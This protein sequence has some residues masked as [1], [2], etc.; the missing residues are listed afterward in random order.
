MRE[1]ISAARWPNG[2]TSD[3]T[4]HARLTLSY[5]DWQIEDFGSANG[6]FVSGVA[7]PPAQ[8][9]M[10]FPQQELRVG[11]V[12]LRLRRLRLQES[13]ESLAPQTAA[14]LR[15]LPEALR[16]LQRY[17]VKGMIAQG[18][19]GVVLEA[20]D[21]V[22]RRRVAMKLLLKPDSA[23]MVARFIEEAQI[24]A[25]LEHPGIVPVYDLNVNELD[26]PFYVMKLVRGESLKQ[27]LNGLRMERSATCEQYPLANLLTAFLKVCEA[28]EYAHAK[29]VVHRDLKPENVMLGRFGEVLILDWGFAKSLEQIEP[30]NRLRTAWCVPSVRPIRARSPLSKGSL[31]ALLDLCPP[32]RPAEARIA[33]IGGRRR[34]PWG[35]SSTTSSRSSLPSITAILRKPSPR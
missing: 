1:V 7:I 16:G 20:E 27:V 2:N 23:E 14:V 24:M 31:W 11:N 8:T 33:W 9:T 35:R 4:R 17:Q 34:I 13:A 15:H 32:N 6:T 12:Q 25:Q 22:T 21:I 5:F 3:G 19:M 28:M 30:E 26:N 10:L 29:N 18:G